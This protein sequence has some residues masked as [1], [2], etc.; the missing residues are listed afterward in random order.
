MS[1]WHGPPLLR[2]WFQRGRIVPT[3][4][5]GVALYQ[6]IVVAGRTVARGR[7]D[8]QGRWDAMAPHLPAAGVFLDIGSNFGWFG[9]K[10][11]AESEQRLVVSVE[12]DEQSATLQRQILASHDQRRMFLLTQRANAAMASAWAAGQ[13]RFQAAFCLSVLHWIPD[14]E[15]F[16]RTLGSITDR[17]FVEHP[18]AREEG[19][20]I[21]AVRREIGSLG[22]YLARLF[23]D[24]NCVPLA[25]LASHR[26]SPHNRELWMVEPS[27]RE[28][29]S[30]TV[31]VDPEFL[32][33]LSTSWPA[34]SW[35]RSELAALSRSEV[36]AANSAVR[37]MITPCGLERTNSAQ[38]ASLA[39]VKLL[40]RRVPEARL[41]TR[42]DWLRQRARQLASTTLANARSF[43][44]T[45]VPSQR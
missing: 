39:R 42:R 43:L 27:C 28:Q 44:A 13:Q 45:N 22:E 32:L 33:R 23:P 30:A 19:A 12:A 24:R 18:D 38:G 15:R 36:D 34:R 26:G 31:S 1:T 29:N 25:N 37:V 40:V 21:G 6:D 14:H 10:A 3:R 41:Y 17:I 2:N 35:W 8:C 5:R 16:M 9:L 7:R 4:R 20:G 11:C